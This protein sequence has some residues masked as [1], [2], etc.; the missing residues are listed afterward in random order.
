MVTGKS[1]KNRGS[2][3]R[4]Q[5]TGLGGFFVLEQYIKKAKVNKPKTV[6][7]QGFGN[8]GSNIAKVLYDQ[9]YQ[10]VAISDINGG[11]LNHNGLNIDSL[12]KCRDGKKQ[13]TDAGGEI[14]SNE[15]LLELPV[16]ILIP[17]ALE[18]VITEKNVSNIK[19]QVILE[20]ANGPT[21]YLASQILNQK[22]VVIIPDVLANSGGVTVSYFEWYQNI[23]NER[24]PLVK[25]NMKLKEKMEEAFSKIWQIH[26]EKKV[27]LKLSAYILALQRLSQKANLK[28]FYQ[29]Q[30]NFQR[31]S[32]YYQPS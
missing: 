6:A 7:I 1:L 29:P 16:D 23:C 15:Q 8:V 25:V 10:I 3:G 12:I 30:G 26:K 9:N 21:S 27:S 14:I 31:Q 20:M 2:L 22:G 17:A 13:L 11:I 32:T 24:W 19:A 4:E 5:A 18:N 28:D